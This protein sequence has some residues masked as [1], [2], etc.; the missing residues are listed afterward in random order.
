MAYL[1][2]CPKIIIH[3]ITLRSGLLKTSG[4]YGITLTP[5]SDNAEANCNS[6][7]ELKSG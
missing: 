6:S 5:A 2:A 4:C 1:F 3:K 7:P